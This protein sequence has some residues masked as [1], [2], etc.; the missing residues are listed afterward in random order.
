MRYYCTLFDRNYLLKG[1]CLVASM[2]E[3]AGDFT[4]YVLTLDNL[5]YNY[6]QDIEGV[7]PFPLSYVERKE[8]KEARHNRTWREYAWTLASQWLKMC[9]EVAPECVYLDADSYFFGDPE[10]IFEETRNDCVAVTP[11]RLTEADTMR[12]L[13]PGVFNVNWV[14]VK[15]GGFQFVNEWADL[16]L[17][18]CYDRHE[19]TRFGDQKYLDMLVP[20]YR[21]HVIQAKGLNLAPWNQIQYK[22][23]CDHGRLTVDGEPVILYHFHEFASPDKLTDWPLNRQVKECIYGPYVE[24]Y[25]Q[26]L[27]K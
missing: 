26:L 14:Q 13:W 10:P 21:G 8:W 9:L 27:A 22:Y 17:D 7:E 4:L 5:T 19:L 6:L 12:T 3:W 16:C 20:K 15:Q 2:K 23:G 18:W 11:H 1:L 24:T 25:N